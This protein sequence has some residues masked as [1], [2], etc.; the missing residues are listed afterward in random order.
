MNPKNVWIG[1]LIALMTVIAAGCAVPPSLDLSLTQATAEKRFVVTL[2]PPT[3]SATLN[4]IH[5]WQIQLSSPDGMPIS[6]AQIA[7]DGSMPQH[8]HGLPTRPQVTPMQDEGRYLLEGMKFSMP[9]WWQIELAIQS[10][11]ATDKATFNTV[12]STPPIEH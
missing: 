11:E 9:G 12:V 5:S 6:H 1:S 7:V 10:P 8:G 4:Q 3:P 2:Q